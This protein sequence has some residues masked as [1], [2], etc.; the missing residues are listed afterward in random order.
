MTTITLDDAE[1]L[2]FIAY[3]KHHDLFVTLE[4]TGA[5]DTQYG[6]V[7]INYSGGVAQNIQIDRIAWKR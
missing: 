7:I 5:L 1:A 6:K 4:A 3:Q 2:L